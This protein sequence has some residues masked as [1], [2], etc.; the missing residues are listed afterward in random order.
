MRI[1]S[2]MVSPLAAEEN[3]RALSVPIVRPPSRSIAA[4]NESRVRV[5]GS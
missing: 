4:S 5:D 1:V 2:S 3:S